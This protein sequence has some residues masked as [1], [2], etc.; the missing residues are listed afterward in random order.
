M[1]R[2]T[3]S[4][5]GI[6]KT[7]SSENETIKVENFL[8]SVNFYNERVRFTVGWVRDIFVVWV[9]YKCRKFMRAHSMEILVKQCSDV[10]GSGI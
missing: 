7:S 2:E 5:E 8:A 4:K 1:G 10:T 9:G 6:P 3:G